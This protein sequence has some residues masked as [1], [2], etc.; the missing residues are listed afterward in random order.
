[1]CSDGYARGFSNTC[2]SCNN[3]EGQLLTWVGFVVSVVIILLLVIFAVVFLIGGLDAVDVVRKCVTR[4]FSVEGIKSRDCFSTRTS[5]RESECGGTQ[6]FRNDTIAPASDFTWENQHRSG[7]SNIGHMSRKPSPT[8]LVPDDGGRAYVQPCRTVAAPGTNVGLAN[9]PAKLSNH[10]AMPTS[11]HARRSTLAVGLDGENKI[12]NG[13]ESCCGWSVSIKV[14]ASRLPLDKLKILVVVWQILTI[15]SG[16]TDVEFPA[17]YA[18]FLSWID[19]VNLDIG[20]IFSASCILPRVNFHA[21]L[22]VTTL[23]PLVLVVGLLLTYSVA[24]SRAGIGSVGVVAK[25]AAWSRHVAA[26]L[27]LTFLVRFSGPPASL[28]KS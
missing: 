26:G 20:H 23:V 10:V 6:D 14:L 22:L 15:F 13:G 17:C 24:K 9:A 19:F 11:Q 4:K 25:K 16:I 18:I 12:D 8:N 7:K 2:H 27:L 1:M 28:R 21:R 5:S 3:T